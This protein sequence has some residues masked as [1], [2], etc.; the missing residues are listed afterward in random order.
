MRLRNFRPRLFTIINPLVGSLF[1]GLLACENQSQERQSIRPVKAI[2]IT[3]QQTPSYRTYPGEIKARVETILSFRVAGKL[4]ERK[5]DIGDPVNKGQLLAILDGNDYRLAVQGLKAQLASA[6]ADSTFL[7]DDLARYRE[8]LTQQVISPPEFERH[9]TAYTAARER[10]AALAAQLAEAF[11]QLSYTELHADR[12]G[13]VTALAVEAGQV[14]AAGQAVMTLARLDE[15]EIHFDVPEH[16]L[17]EIQRQQ[18]VNVSLW[19]DERRFR[20]KIREI[21]SAADPASRTYRVKATLLEGLDAAQLGMTATVHMAANNASAIAIPLSAIYTRQNQPDHTL[22]WLV[23]EQTATVKSVP[24]KLG[25]TLA[26][27]RIAV[28][29]LAAGQLLVSAGVQRLAEGQA[30]RLP[31]G[32]GLPKNNGSKEQL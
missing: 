12:D 10:T 21:A 30:V 13:V 11:N 17:A 5:I 24:V 18:D 16:R 25:E 29:G 23:D 4:L 2:R 1:L 26:G 28:E 14:L 7:R 19:V 6:Q 32:S 27:E 15:K 22:V 20:A 8:L 9:E 3:S 31:E